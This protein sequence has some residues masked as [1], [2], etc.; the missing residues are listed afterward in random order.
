MTVYAKIEGHYIKSL[1]ELSE[2]HGVGKGNLCTIALCEFLEA[3]PKTQV[4]AINKSRVKLE[5][6]KLLAEKI[7]TEKHLAE[8]VEQ[9][10]KMSA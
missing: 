1:N 8:V 9:L 6:Q 2:V 7:K 4:T 5:K 10:E 3:D